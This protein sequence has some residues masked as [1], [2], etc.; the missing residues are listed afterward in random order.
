MENTAQPMQ[1]TSQFISITHH[2]FGSNHGAAAATRR[3]TT[4]P[5]NQAIAS[6]PIFVEIA[7]EVTKNTQ[8]S[9]SPPPH[10]PKLTSITHCHFGNNHGAAAI[11]Q[12]HQMIPHHQAI[13]STPILT[14]IA[15]KLA[16]I[17]PIKCEAL[18][19]PSK[20]TPPSFLRINL[21]QIVT[22]PPA[23]TM[24]H[25]SQHYLLVQTPS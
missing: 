8:S 25:L 18:P 4:V 12:Q 14:E 2:R 3:F 16:K 10:H 11:H 9:S 24:S 19:T 17:H 23:L 13:A 22:T 15:Q 21:S 7:Q 1:A 20:T 6:T 5:H